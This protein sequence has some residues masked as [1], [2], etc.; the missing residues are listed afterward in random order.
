MR[1]ITIGDWT[2]LGSTIKAER[3]RAKL[4]QHELAARAGISRS[5]LA[6]VEAGHRGAEF[7]QILRLLDALGLSMILRSEAHDPEDKQG[8]ITTPTPRI[9]LDSKAMLELMG[10][11]RDSAAVRRDAWS[12]GAAGARLLGTLNAIEAASGAARDSKN[13]TETSADALRLGR[14]DR[15]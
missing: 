2:K 7:E 13:E 6:K 10:K 5:W 12:A 14:V 1:D 3:T 15:G 11:H 4:S 9:S 8:T